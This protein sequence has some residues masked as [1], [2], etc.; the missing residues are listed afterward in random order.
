MSLTIQH[1]NA[2]STFLLAFSPAPTT[3]AEEQ[4]RI[5]GAFTILLDPWLVGRSS[6][7]HPSFQYTK[8]T[9]KPH[10]DSLADIKQEIDLII[11][12]QEKPDHCNRETLCSLPADKPVTILATPAAAKKIKSWNH[13]APSHIH[14]LPPFKPSHPSTLTRIP[15]PPTTPTLHPGELTIAHLPAKHDLTRVHNALGIT[16]RPPSPAAPTPDNPDPT[17]TLSLLYTPHGTPPSTIAPYTTAHLLPTHA[18]PLTALLHGFNHEQ[19]PACLGGEVMRGAPGGLELLRALDGRVRC[20]IAAHDGEVERGGW[21]VRWLRS[22]AFGAREV[23]GLVGGEGWGT[24]VRV[25]GVGEGVRLG[26]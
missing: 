6:I 4:G 3:P 23:Q 5:P 10:I 9:D 14:T 11:I 21:S 17:P 16:Y 12:T 7:F 25:L 13:F 24:E 18:L 19:N 1:L 22:R 8:H 20:W 2:D 26:G 15:L